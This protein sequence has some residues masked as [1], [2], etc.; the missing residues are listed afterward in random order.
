MESLD[1]SIKVDRDRSASLLLLYCL[2]SRLRRAAIVLQ[3]VRCVLHSPLNTAHGMCQ[4][5]SG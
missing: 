1:R 4:E 3:A 5:H 2:A